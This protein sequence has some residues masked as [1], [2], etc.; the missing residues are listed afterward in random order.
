[1]YNPKN[2]INSEKHKMNIILRIQSDYIYNFLVWGKFLQLLKIF[3]LRKKQQMN[4]S[5]NYYSG[6]VAK[7]NVF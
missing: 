4:D 3:K 6:I 7:R 5:F 2:K 1:M